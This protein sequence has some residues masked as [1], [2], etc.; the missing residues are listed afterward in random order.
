MKPKNQSSE[1]T[2]SNSKNSN[3]N[4][5]SN[6][7]FAQKNNNANSKSPDSIDVADA[8]RNEDTLYYLVERG[9]E[10]PF[11]SNML[12]GSLDLNLELSKE[13]IDLQV[14]NKIRDLT[15][16]L[17]QENKSDVLWAGGKDRNE[18][19]SGQAQNYKDSR[20][21]DWVAAD[22]KANNDLMMGKDLET[23]FHSEDDD[24]LDL[25]F[26]RRS[27]DKENNGA[28]NLNSDDGYYAPGL[29]SKGYK[30]ASD[31]KNMDI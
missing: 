24:S 9:P 14:V 20:D 12:N 29:G 10:N 16:Q 26:Y 28:G 8:K 23:N 17:Q 1:S 21:A 18:V 30:L 5:E 22:K 6:S 11:L 27:S 2:N 15:D 3:K 19:I 13:E 4:K 7:N 25:K 31:L